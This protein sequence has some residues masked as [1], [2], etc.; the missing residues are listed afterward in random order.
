M[1]LKVLDSS[2]TFPFAKLCYISYPKAKNFFVKCVKITFTKKQYNT[3]FFDFFIA[4]H[5]N[6][7][8]IYEGATSNYDMTLMR[9]HVVL[10]F[11]SSRI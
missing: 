4:G 10:G 1:F 5:R 9:Q 11:S 2:I 8:G 3:N 6:A 7:I